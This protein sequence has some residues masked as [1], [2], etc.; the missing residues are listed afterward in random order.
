MRNARAVPG[1]TASHSASSG[2]QEEL[3][4]RCKIKEGESEGD[5]N[6]RDVESQKATPAKPQ[7]Q[8]KPQPQLKPQPEK[9]LGGKTCIKVKKGPLPPNKRLMSPEDVK[10]T[11]DECRSVMT[12]W[13]IVALQD[14]KYDG[15][16]Y[17][18][19]F[20]D[21]NHLGCGYIGFMLLMDGE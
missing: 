11:S 21:G 15:A 10:R 9:D 17:G 8:P 14:A 16:S 5:D 13:E 18:Y 12:E 2:G 7:P 1:R 3:H 20:T 6:A 4:L 19:K